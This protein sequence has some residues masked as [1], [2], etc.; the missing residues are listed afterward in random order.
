MQGSQIIQLFK[1][2]SNIT[3]REIMAIY[4]ETQKKRCEIEFD[5]NGDAGNCFCETTTMIYRDDV[6]L[7]QSHHRDVIEFEKMQEMVAKAVKAKPVDIA[8]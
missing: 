8:I 2:L 1:E 4:T 7:S 6:F 5:E 3:Y